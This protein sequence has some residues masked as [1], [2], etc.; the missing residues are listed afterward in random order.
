MKKLLRRFLQ[1][2][3]YSEDQCAAEPRPL[4][5]V[6]SGGPHSV[7][8]SVAMNGYVLSYYDHR[9]DRSITFVS[10]GGIEDVHN[11]LVTIIAAANLNV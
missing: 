11:K 6:V 3:M 9:T 8:V 7:N 2:V 10:E 1:W 4:G 5:N